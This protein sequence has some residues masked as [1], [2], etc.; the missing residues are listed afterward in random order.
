MIITDSVVR[1]QQ[2]LYECSARDALRAHWSAYQDARGRTGVN[3]EPRPTSLAAVRSPRTRRA[4][5]RLIANPS[6]NR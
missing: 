6:A 4:R 3:V 1:R 2:S 5:S